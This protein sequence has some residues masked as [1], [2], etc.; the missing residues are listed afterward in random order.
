M[1]IGAV[2]DPFFAREV[3]RSIWMWQKKQGRHGVPAEAC[4]LGQ[5]GA[6]AKPRIFPDRAGRCFPST[7]RSPIARWI[8]QTA[9]RNP[10][11]ASFSLPRFPGFLSWIRI[12]CPATAGRFS[13]FFPSSRAC[14][15][16]FWSRERTSAQKVIVCMTDL[17]ESWRIVKHH[18]TRPG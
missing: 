8:T 6:T 4:G 15:V 3:P 10:V 16:R 9:S 11:R 13:I 14:N 5:S 12:N 7:L 17:S 2:S 18:W 1:Q